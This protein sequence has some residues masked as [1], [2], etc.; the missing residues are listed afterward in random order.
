M[1]VFVSVI[2]IAAVVGLVAYPLLAKQEVAVD[3][4]PDRRPKKAERMRQ[5]DSELSSIQSALEQLEIDVKSGVV[6]EEEYVDRRVAHVRR[7]EAIR[8]GWKEPARDT[9]IGA[10]DDIERRVA[11]LR[12]LKGRVCP[13]CRAPV[14]ANDKSCPECGAQIRAGR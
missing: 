9:G 6:T 13:K 5:L 4:R 3:R 14:R 12:R 10:A 7:A 11:E 1:V 2:L 8:R